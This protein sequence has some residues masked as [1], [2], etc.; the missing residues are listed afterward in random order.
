M[1]TQFLATLEFENYS[2]PVRYCQWYKWYK[3]Y[4]VNYILQQDTTVYSI[5]C[6]FPVAVVPIFSLL[7]SGQLE[8]LCFSMASEVVYHDD[9][10]TS[11]K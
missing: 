3:W 1:N 4:N 10:A 6:S 9:F 8:Y 11:R 5:P 2:F 7:S